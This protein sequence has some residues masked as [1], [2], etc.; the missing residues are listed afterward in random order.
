MYYRIQRNFDRC[1]SFE[2][3]NV[4]LNQFLYKNISYTYAMHTILPFCMKLQIQNII[5]YRI[6]FLRNELIMNVE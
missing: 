5:I 3:S 1:V 6:E 2:K 4:P